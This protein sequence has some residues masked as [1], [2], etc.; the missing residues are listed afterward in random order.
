MYVV[1]I[2]L[3]WNVW[4]YSNLPFNIYGQV[5]VWFIF[6]WF[7]L[8][9]IGIVVDDYIRYWL[10]DEEKRLQ[11]LIMFH[12]SSENKLVTL[13]EYVSRMKEE[14]K[15][16]YYASGESISKIELLTQIELIKDKGFEVLYVTEEIDEFALGVLMN[17][18]EKEF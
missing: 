13:D 11:D 3:G 16:I 14:Q 9:F 2:G 12:S 7:I 8:S 10:F 15:F 4:D 6:L 17:D 18:K 5:C 1:N